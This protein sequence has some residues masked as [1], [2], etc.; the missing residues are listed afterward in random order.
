[1]N[2]LFVFIGGGLGALVRY[3]LCLVTP[4]TLYFPAGTIISNFLGCFIATVAFVYL[5]DKI[6]I[7]PA[8]KNFLIIGFCGGLSTLSA[9]SLELLN[10]IH[11]GEF[12][13]AVSY[14]LITLIVCTVS[15]LLG[16]ILVRHSLNVNY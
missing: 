3:F 8:Y 2:G 7:N 9:L 12:L 1:M 15:V 5:F 16:L 6:N 14:V 10:F 4:K 11:N 13:R